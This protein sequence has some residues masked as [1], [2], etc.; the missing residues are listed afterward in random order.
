[1]SLGRWLAC[2]KVTRNKAGAQGP[3][4]ARHPCPLL[5]GKLQ[6]QRVGMQLQRVRRAHRP[7]R[8]CAQAVEEAAPTAGQ[9]AARPASMRLTLRAGGLAGRA[10][11][12]HVPFWRDAAWLARSVAA[13]APAGGAAAEGAS[14]EARPP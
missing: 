5:T 10:A 13:G 1:M 7:A 3:T 2:A 8:A 6:V 12:S 9:P 11:F 4:A 14:A